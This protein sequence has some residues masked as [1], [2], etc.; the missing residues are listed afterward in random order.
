MTEPVLIVGAGVSGI[1][2]ARHLREQ[3]P[4]RSFVILEAQDDR[5]GT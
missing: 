3:S 1:G 4:N 2:A 5:G